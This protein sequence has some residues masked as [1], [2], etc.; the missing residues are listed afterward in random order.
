MFLALVTFAKGVEGC[1]MRREY[2]GER[3]ELTQRGLGHQ[4]FLSI[5]ECLSLIWNQIDLV[6]IKVVT[7]ELLK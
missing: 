3:R 1:E 5:I 6:V 7:P 4:S 2:M